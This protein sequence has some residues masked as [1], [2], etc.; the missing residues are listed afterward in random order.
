MHC[1]R[2]AI[3]HGNS[4]ADARLVKICGWMQLK[5]KE[6]LKINSQTV[7][8]YLKAAIQ[9]MELVGD[10]IHEGIPNE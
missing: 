8:E 4:L 7:R 9:Y 1:V 5:E 6:P 3:V 2:N 10:F